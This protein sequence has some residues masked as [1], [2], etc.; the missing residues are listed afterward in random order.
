MA[1][2][3]KLIGRWSPEAALKRCFNKRDLL[4]EIIAFFFKD[5]DSLLPQ[6]RAALQQGDLAE[7]GRLGHRMKGTLLHLGAE[8]AKEAAEAVERFMLHAGTQTEAKKAVRAF[9]RQC[10]VLRQALSPHRP[11]ASPAESD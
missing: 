3:D 2:F 5:A 9:E 7:V 8:P 11:A 4:Q 1:I 6:I 10:K